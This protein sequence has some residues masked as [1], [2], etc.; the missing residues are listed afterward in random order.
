MAEILEMNCLPNGKLNG[1]IKQ[2]QMATY[3]YN[4]RHSESDTVT[5]NNFYYSI[6]FFNKDNKC[7]RIKNYDGDH[8]S[9]YA[10]RLS[11]NKNGLLVKTRD[12]GDCVFKFDHDYTY[13]IND[14]IEEEVWLRVVKRKYIYNDKGQLTKI[15][16]YDKR[17]FDSVITYKY[18]NNGN[19]IEECQ[20]NKDNALSSKTV[21]T[22]NSNGKVVKECEFDAKGKPGDSTEYIYNDSNA[23]TQKIY[24]HSSG[25]KGVAKY[26]SKGNKIEL[27]GFD[28]DGRL[29]SITTYSYDSHQNVYKVESTKFYKDGEKSLELDLFSIDYR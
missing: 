26:D 28:S 6:F 20:F 11:Y 14:R 21:Y 27:K 13:G 22:Y 3:R 2:I 9:D 10:T 1:N 17:K 16:E 7:V 12:R 15:V 4:Y 8:K 24:Y 18:D 19:K 29:S 25:G 23:L 5:Y